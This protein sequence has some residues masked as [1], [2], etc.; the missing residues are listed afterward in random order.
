[1]SL[2]GPR[3]EVPEYV[4]LEN[5]LWRA[6]LDV[7]PGITDPASLV[8]RDEEAVLSR[9][10]DPEAFYRRSILPAKLSINLQYLRSRCWN[11]DLTLLVLTARCSFFASSIDPRLV[12]KT[13]LDGVTLYEPRF[14]HPVSYS[15]DR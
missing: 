7:R 4:D 3:P 14:I 5:P 15:L 10:K 2:I 8:F 6:V 13:F 9:A 11:L 1:M 12:T